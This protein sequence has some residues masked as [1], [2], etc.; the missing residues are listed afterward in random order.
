MEGEEKKQQQIRCKQY[1]SHLC[2]YI[3]VYSY[4]HFNLL[5]LF[6]CDIFS[7]ALS[8]FLRYW[9]WRQPEGGSR[10]KNATDALNLQS[11]CAV[12]YFR[13]NYY[14]APDPFIYFCELLFSAEK[15]SANIDSDWVRAIFIGIAQ[16][17][18]GGG[19]GAGEKRARE[20]EVQ[21]THVATCLLSLF[22][23]LLFSFR[24][25]QAH[26]TA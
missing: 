12:Y 2:K 22:F 7:N 19:T 3:Q 1:W 16:R 26:L 11:N 8:R 9:L 21:W 6:V 20:Q 10:N 24:I 5:C 4:T 13:F 14:R 15:S 18:R 23:H 25:T 17:T